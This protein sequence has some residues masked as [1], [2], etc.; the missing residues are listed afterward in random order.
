MPDALQLQKIGWRDT[1]SAEHI[2]DL[3]QGA[4]LRQAPPRF[5]I[6][7]GCLAAPDGLRETALLL[8]Q[9]RAKRFEPFRKGHRLQDEQ[10]RVT[11]T[12]AAGAFADLVI[13]SIGAPRATID[14]YRKRNAAQIQ[15]AFI[16]P[17]T[18]P[19]PHLWESRTMLWNCFPTFDG[20]IFDLTASA[21]DTH[22]LHRPLDFHRHAPSVTGST[23]TRC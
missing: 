12:I 20:S 21:L 11:R 8:E 22:R 10:P 6:R 13:V 17:P 14:D 15:P 23:P 1:C 16:D 5:P 19:T 9:P 7:D 3:S 4:W 18:P 2:E